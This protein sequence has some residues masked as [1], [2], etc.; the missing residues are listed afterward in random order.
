MNQEETEEVTMVI[1]MMNGEIGLRH[2]TVEI[3]Y[4]DKT[5]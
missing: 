2:Q 4:L 1:L 3:I 5:H